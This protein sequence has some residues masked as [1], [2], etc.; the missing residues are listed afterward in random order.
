MPLIG[1]TLAVI[2]GGSYFGLT[3]STVVF[4]THLVFNAIANCFGADTFF[5]SSPSEM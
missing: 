5:P 2:N 4:L 3:R 1:A